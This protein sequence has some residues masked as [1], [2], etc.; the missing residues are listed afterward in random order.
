[1]QKIGMRPILSVKDGLVKAA[2]LKMQA[3]NTAQA[4]FKQAEEVIKKPLEEGKI[5]RVAI[6][7]A[8]ALEEAEK[9]K[10]MFEEKYPQVEVSFIALTGIVVG[11]H[12][13]PG[14]L[15]ISCSIKK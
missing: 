3:K 10:K 7:H 11:C 5:C 12:V 6:S 15:L 8:D 1:M 14:T 9:L 4:L 13:G 2:N